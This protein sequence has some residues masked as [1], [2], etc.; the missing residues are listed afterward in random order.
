MV[1]HE[2]ELRHRNICQFVNVTRGD[3]ERMFFVSEHY[4]RS[5]LDLLKGGAARTR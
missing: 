2:Q 5:V 1:H 4:D 3:M